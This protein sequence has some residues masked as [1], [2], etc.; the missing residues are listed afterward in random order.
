MRVEQAIDPPLGDGAD[1]GR[2]DGQEVRGERERLAVEV[3]GRLDLSRLQYDRVV[4]RRG[5]LDGG[6]AAGKLQRV[7]RRSRDLRAAPHRVGILHRVVRVA[8][9]GDDAG[10]PH[11]PYQVGRAR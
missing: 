2:G 3:A 5:K 6:D 7:A 1:L 11:Q 10:T 4:D 9:R 8:M